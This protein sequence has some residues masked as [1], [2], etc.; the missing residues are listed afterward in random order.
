MLYE[1]DHKIPGPSKLTFNILILQS[2]PAGLP[3]RNSDLSIMSATLSETSDPD[4]DSF[5]AAAAEAVET[6]ASPKKKLQER[7]RPRRARPAREKKN[8]SEVRPKSNCY[9]VMILN[10]VPLINVPVGVLACSQRIMDKEWMKI[11]AYI[12]VNKLNF[13]T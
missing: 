13:V 10:H 8:A 2:V 3:N 4:E 11:E 5:L 9:L 1:K 7:G 6:A 12:N